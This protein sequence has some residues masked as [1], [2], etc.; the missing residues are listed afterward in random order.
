MTA[1]TGTYR[2]MAPEVIA[3]QHY[4]HKCDVFSYG[5][6][7]WE[8]VSGGDIPYSGYTP[9]QAAVGVVQRGLRPTI[10]ATCHPVVAQVMQYCW[11]PDPNARPEFEQ[12]VELL[13][14]TESPADAAETKGFFSRLRNISRS[15]SAK[16]G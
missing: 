12:V 8:L 11:Q 14:H 5:I 13:R 1:E 10:P 3:H 16:A 15:S 4:T 2:W 7:L 9:L 6:L